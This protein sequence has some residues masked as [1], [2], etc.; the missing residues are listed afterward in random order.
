M[1]LQPVG[2]SG[3]SRRFWSVQMLS[4]KKV[5]KSNSCFCCFR[6]ICWTKQQITIGRQSI[7]KMCQLCQSRKNSLHFPV[8]QFNF[9]CNSAPSPWQKQCV[10][11]KTG[12]TLSQH[13][14]CPHCGLTPTSRVSYTGSE[15]EAY[16]LLMN[17]E[18]ALTRPIERHWYDLSHSRG[19]AHGSIHWIKLQSAAAYI[20]TASW[21]QSNATVLQLSLV[22]GINSHSEEES[23]LYLKT[24]PHSSSNHFLFVCVGR[25]GSQNARNLNDSHQPTNQQNITFE[26]TGHRAADLS[27]VAIME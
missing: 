5:R 3:S 16:E 10:I 2:R 24:T 15:T 22:D 17:S 25:A 7:D 4:E 12:A 27:P 19:G 21:N 14:P 20:R 11:S 1:V 9:D 23:S 6:D 8:E 18:K 26:V 13:F